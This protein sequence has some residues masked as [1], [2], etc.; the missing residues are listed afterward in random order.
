[1]REYFIVMIKEGETTN[2]KLLAE[3]LNDGFVVDRLQYGC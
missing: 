2:L 1:M 3:K